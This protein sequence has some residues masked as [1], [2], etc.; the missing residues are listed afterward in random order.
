MDP[1]APTPAPHP[2]RFTSLLL[3]LTG[4]Y[5]VVLVAAT[6]Y[7]K[8]Q[9]LLE[10]SPVRSD[11]T[12]HFIAYGVLG[13][14]AASTLAAAD[15]W[16]WRSLL[17]VTLVLLVFAALDEATQPLFGRYA[18]PRDWCYDVVG[19]GLGL[20]CVGLTRRRFGDRLQRL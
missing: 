15:R 1:R 8:P 14:L 18:D 11:K 19:L 3:G 4:A 2:H 16:H 5:T 20:L 12:L 6:H 10:Y 13:T 17:A 7:P 9:E